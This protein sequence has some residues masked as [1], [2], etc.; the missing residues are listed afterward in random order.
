MPAPAVAPPPQNLNRGAFGETWRRQ[1]LQ[2]QGIPQGARSL[3]RNQRE[4]AAALGRSCCP[5][6]PLRRATSPRLPFVQEQEAAS[7]R[8][9]RPAGI[10]P[11]APA[12]Q[13]VGEGTGRTL[14]RTHRTRVRFRRPP[15]GVLQGASS[16]GGRSGG[17]V[18]RQV[19]RALA[20]AAPPARAAPHHNDDAQ[21]AQPFIGNGVGRFNPAWPWHGVAGEHWRAG[22]H[23]RAC[24]R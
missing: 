24:L 20:R 1:Y 5:R 10:A 17:G 8:T 23:Y 6:Y 9:R 12:A 15:R 18:P 4:C 21:A 14:N 11:K 3:E 19:P 16:A 13:G 2:S 7:A 22:S